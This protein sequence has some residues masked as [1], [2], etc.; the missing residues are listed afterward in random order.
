MGLFN[1]RE[2]LEISTL[3]SERE[4]RLFKKAES[5]KDTEDKKDWYE[6]HGHDLEVLKN[7]INKTEKII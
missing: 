6:Y 4:I 7:I 1:R 2:L 3:A 5:I